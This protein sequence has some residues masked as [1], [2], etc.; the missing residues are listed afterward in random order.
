M[1]LYILAFI[2]S[3][4]LSSIVVGIFV[5]I[6][7]IK[8]ELKSTLGLYY[9]NIQSLLNSEKEKQ[10]AITELEFTKQYL[11]QMN[12]SVSEIAKRP[13]MVV[14]NDTQI[15]QISHLVGDIVK[16]ALTPKEKA[17]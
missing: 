15:L 13:S 17:D 6:I 7:K 3:I 4:I 1:I 12:S 2:S 11:I 9:T 16:S 14:L 8:Q 10:A 5:Y